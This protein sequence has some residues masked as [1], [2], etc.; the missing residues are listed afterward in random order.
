MRIIKA[1][2]YHYHLLDG[3]LPKPL[4]S[5]FANW[6]MENYAKRHDK[7][8]APVLDEMVR[9]HDVVVPIENLDWLE[10][11]TVDRCNRA[12][13]WCPTNK[14]N[15]TRPYHRMSDEL[16][17]KIIDD[18]A[19]FNYK[20][21]LG[22]FCYNEPLMDKDIVQRVGYAKRM[23]PG[24]HHFIYSNC[25]LLAPTKLYE[26]DPASFKTVVVDNFRKLADV[27]DC[28]V[29]DNYSDDGELTPQIQAVWDAC[30]DEYP[31][32]VI[33]KRRAD[34]VLNTKGS[35]APN[36]RR[37]NFNMRSKCYLPFTG[38][39]VDPFGRV[40]LCC[41]DALWH[42]QPLGDLSASTVS[43][44]W[45]GPGYR[46]V[47]EHY[48]SDGKRRDKIVCDCCDVFHMGKNRVDITK[49]KY[50]EKMRLPKV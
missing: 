34:E 43:E 22:L 12:C 40:R 50:W 11:E 23:L 2:D 35:Q 7:L 14:N 25:D 38:M 30:K 1:A 41:Q 4:M 21:C 17:K 32:F 26:T 28:M 24:A 19:S 20:G 33:W 36:R 47:R 45:N 27:L 5:R 49:D 31:N 44:V 37:P 8:M 46:G 6:Y 39:Y 13:H 10:I 15:D 18:L 42:H 16:F 29:L 48:L 3:V 9:K